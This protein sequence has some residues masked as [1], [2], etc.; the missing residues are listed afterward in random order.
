[1]RRTIAGMLNPMFATSCIGDDSGFERPTAEAMD[2][3]EDVIGPLL[4]SKWPWILD[5]GLD[6]RGSA[7]LQFDG[8]V[9]NAAP[10]LLDCQIGEDALDL[11][12]S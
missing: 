6:V 11:I 8:R 4:P 5:D 7:P 10:D 12:E 1:M 2:G 3:R 9:V